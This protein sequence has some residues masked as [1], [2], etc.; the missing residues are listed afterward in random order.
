MLRTL[1]GDSQGEAAV[2]SRR[3][4]ADWRLIVFL[5]LWLSPCGSPVTYGCLSDRAGLLNIRTAWRPD[6]PNC[7]R[8]TL[9]R[10]F[11]SQSKRILGSVGQPNV[12]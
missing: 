1:Q 5:G 10:L 4:E 2:T 3:V 6:V 9:P 12:A 7:A 8:G 11:L